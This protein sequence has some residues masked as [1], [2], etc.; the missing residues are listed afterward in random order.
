MS[1]LTQ[2]TEVSSPKITLP[3]TADVL[4]AESVTVLEF[5]AVLTETTVAPA[6]IPSPVTDTP[7]ITPLTEPSLAS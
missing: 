5:G 3:L 4:F 1:I 6:P 2:L 7:S